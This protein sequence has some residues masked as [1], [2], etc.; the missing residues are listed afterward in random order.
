MARGKA[1]E[2]VKATLEK[3]NSDIKMTRREFIKASAAF[4]AA[5]AGVPYSL[6]DITNVF[7]KEDGELV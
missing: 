4:G 7:L 6:T 2:H 1:E 3:L 5:A